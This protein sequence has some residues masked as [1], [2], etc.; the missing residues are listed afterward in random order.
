MAQT[1]DGAARIP[2][3]LRTLS[4]YRET[5]SGTGEGAPGSFPPATPHLGSGS[6]LKRRSNSMPSNYQNGAEP[7][8]LHAASAMARWEK[9][10][11]TLTLPTISAGCGHPPP[12]RTQVWPDLPPE[13]HR[14]IGSV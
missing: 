14:P 1:V 3:E 11:T 7:V 5:P 4:W 9:S 8:S 13:A 6:H 2:A 12:P 10:L